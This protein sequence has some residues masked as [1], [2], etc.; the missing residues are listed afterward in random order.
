MTE[1]ENSYIVNLTNVQV[2]RQQ[3]ADIFMYLTNGI[4]TA[5]IKFMSRVK[6][7]TA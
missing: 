5:P 3:Y 2:N 1:S 7:A 6:W 4:P